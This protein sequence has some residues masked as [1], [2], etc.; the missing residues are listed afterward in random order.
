MGNHFYSMINEREIERYLNKNFNVTYINLPHYVNDNKVWTVNSYL[1]TGTK[2][3]ER[4]NK[5]GLNRIFIYRDEIGHILFKRPIS[6]NRKDDIT[7][8]RIA[9]DYRNFRYKL[10]YKLKNN[11][12]KS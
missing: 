6:N 7:I 1:I 2:S 12:K 5:D 8:I 11:G 10:K 3:F 4:F 9:F